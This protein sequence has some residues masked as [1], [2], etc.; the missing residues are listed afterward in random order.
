MKI[1]F[2]GYGSMGSMILNG[3]L[4]SK[5]IHN[6]E[7]MVSN[8]T[9][10]K[11][12]D[13]KKEYPEI[14]ITDKNGA[15]AEKC[16]IIFIF[17]NTGEVRNVLEEIIRIRGHDAEK[18]HIIH[19]SAGL[20]IETTEKIFSG[21]ITRVIP[22]LTSEVKE[23]ISL[24]CHNSKVSLNDKN[25]VE[26]LFN[27]I[28]HVKVI[29]ENDFDVATD[30]TSCAP[31]FMANIMKHFAD[32]S[33]EISGF[34]EKEAEEMVLKTVTGT[35]KLLT[36]KEMSFDEVVSRVA[37]KGGITEEGIKSLDNDLPEV[38]SNLFKKTADK[39]EILKDDLENQ[40]RKSI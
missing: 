23:G 40:Y 19:I 8:R 32:I 39:R 27:H 16:N 24:V 26:S 9:L 11:L 35:I 13:L 30:I 6:S 29:D 21:K 31:A 5:L 37:T 12:K 28:S 36:Q 1:G 15:L 18:I 20:N 10:S 2:I 34:S 14:E 4:E 38:F 22:S 17:V 3:F 7:I 25:F 33:A